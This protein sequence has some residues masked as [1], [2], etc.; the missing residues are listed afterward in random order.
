MREWVAFWNSENC[1]YVNARHRDVHYRLIADDI[2]AYVPGPDATVLDYGC[3]EALHAERIA[4]NAGRLI[5]SDAAANVRA[6]LSQRFEAEPRIDIRSPDQVAA[7]PD[8][9]IDVIAMVSVAQYLTPQQLDELLGMFRR[10]LKPDGRLV[11]ADVVSPS[12]STVS[13]VTAL[14]R[15]AAAHGFLGP[16]ILGLVRTTLSTYSKLRTKLGLTRYEEPAMLQKL[17]SAG[18]AAERAPRNVGH[19]AG[20]MTF[21]ATPAA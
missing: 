13:D 5:L 20:R 4:A 15:F 17:S 9:S 12:V 19:H 3:G 18:F 16:A 14:L 2:R 6:A 1:I 21:L 10:L 7:L 8:S 11:L